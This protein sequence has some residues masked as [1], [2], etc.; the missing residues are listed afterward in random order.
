MM[1]YRTL[2]GRRDT[3]DSIAMVSM[4]DADLWLTVLPRRLLIDMYCM[5]PCGKLFLARLETR[6]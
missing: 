3:V 4:I 2:D 1:A 6:L 5:Q